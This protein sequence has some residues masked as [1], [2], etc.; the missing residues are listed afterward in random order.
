MTD[1]SSALSEKDFEAS[2][3]VPDNEVSERDRMFAKRS[4]IKNDF[5]ELLE[6]NCFNG[7]ANRKNINRNQRKNAVQ[8]HKF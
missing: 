1:R 7:S 3:I 6:N 8:I 5:G 4:R 2:K